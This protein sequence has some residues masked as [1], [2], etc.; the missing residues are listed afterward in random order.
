METISDTGNPLISVI[1]PMYK[2]EHFIRKCVQ[3][4]LDQ[5]YSN[6]QLILVDDGS[7]DN[8]GAI[9]DAYARKDNRVFVVHIDNGGVS[10]ARNRG[11]ELAK[12]K[13]IAFVDSD[14]YIDPDFLADAYVC[15]SKNDDDMYISGLQMET[16]RFGTLVDTALNRGKEKRY[17]VRELLEA[18]NVD[19]PFICICGVWCK[20]YRTDV[21]NDHQIRFEKDMTL[22]EDM[23]FICDYLKHVSSIYFSEKVFYH[24]FRGNEESLFSK[25]HQDLYELT[26]RIY[27]IMRGSMCRVSCSADS[28][29]RFD[30][31]Y[32]RIL[33]GCVY[34]EFMFCD[35]ST[36]QSRREVIRKVISNRFVRRCTLKEY[37]N[38][39]DILVVSMLKLGMHRLTHFIFTAH[40]CKR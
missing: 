20:L 18:F 30:A 6:L 32:A 36:E 17:S 34:H 31:L 23:V 21:I 24:Y 11:M 9:C 33:I 25:Y 10:S 27:D 2:A 1:V 14:D 38:P 28:I 16:F 3:S 5:T 40:Y 19:Y 13:Y 39:K 35:K 12:G 4:I 8:S 29:K 15:I 26:V 22:G 7:P 37:R